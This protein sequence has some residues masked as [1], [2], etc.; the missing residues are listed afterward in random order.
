MLSLNRLAEIKDGK[1]ILA[2]QLL[3]LGAILLDD[4][5]VETDPTIVR[6]VPSAEISCCRNASLLSLI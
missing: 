4:G 5:N 3:G 6:F 1:S 2:R